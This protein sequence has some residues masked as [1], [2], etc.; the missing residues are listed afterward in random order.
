MTAVFTKFNN[1]VLFDLIPG[2][3]CI[4]TNTYSKDRLT[5]LF[6]CK[7]VSLLCGRDLDKHIKM[8]YMMHFK[9]D[10]CTDLHRI[11]FSNREALYYYT[12]VFYKRGHPQKE[13]L[14]FWRFYH[15]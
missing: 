9:A 1:P 2:Q 13:L 15:I 5:E 3:L 7:D 4:H 8:N 10:K 12:V 14:F 11:V 6:F